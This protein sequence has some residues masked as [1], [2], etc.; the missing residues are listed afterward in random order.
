MGFGGKACYPHFTDGQAKAERACDLLQ[1]T[2]WEMP[3]L[4]QIQDPTA[5][6]ASLLACIS[7]SYILGWVT[8]E[9]GV[10]GFCPLHPGWLIWKLGVSVHTSK[11]V[12]RDSKRF[13]V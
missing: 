4:D 12:E 3:E 13:S 7:A 9:W 11:Y 2:W 8:W 5:P 10:G 6:K 1:V